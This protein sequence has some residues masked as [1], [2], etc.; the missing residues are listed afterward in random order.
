MIDK[1]ALSPRDDKRVILPNG[2]NTLPI[3]HWRT[4]HPSLYNMNI[5]T[6]KL[7]EKGSLLNLTHNA[8]G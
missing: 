1:V 8:L 4:R 6:Q 3:G 7:A 5:N 2:I